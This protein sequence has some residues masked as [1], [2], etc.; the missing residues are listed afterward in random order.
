MLNDRNLEYARLS[1]FNLRGMRISNSRVSSTPYLQHSYLRDSN[2][3][4]IPTL[5]GANLTE[6]VAILCKL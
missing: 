3:E 5:T 6:C 1:G 2:P 4:G